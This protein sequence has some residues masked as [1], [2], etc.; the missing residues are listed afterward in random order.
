MK[1]KKDTSYHLTSK[2]SN[3]ED[4][5]TAISTSSLRLDASK[6][7]DDS[8]ITIDAACEK[9]NDEL[10]DECDNNNDSL[11]VFHSD[12]VVLICNK[13][14]IAGGKAISNKKT[15]SKIKCIVLNVTAKVIDKGDGDEQYMIFPRKGDAVGSFLVDKDK[16][17]G[18]VI[19]CFNY[20]SYYLLSS[21]KNVITA[22][23]ARTTAR[24]LHLYLSSKS[25]ADADADGK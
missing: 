8:P 17:C 25:V 4:Y 2:I 6:L 12:V 15:H 5:F 20:L 21:S 16:F 23:T 13:P 3:E 1:S 11:V 24:C 10:D 7:P 9:D 19:I 18:T 22:T 14:G